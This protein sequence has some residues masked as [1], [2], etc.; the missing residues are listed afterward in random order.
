MNLGVSHADSAPSYYQRDFAAVVVAVVDSVGAFFAA[1]LSKAVLDFQNSAQNFACQIDSIAMLAV[2]LPEPKFLSQ[3]LP[4]CD[5][6]SRTRLG[7]QQW[8]QAAPALR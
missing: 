3:P 5:R 7:K 6:E 1:V 4:R 2:V 8:V